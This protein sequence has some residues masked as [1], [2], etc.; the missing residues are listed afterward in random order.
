[1]DGVL[2]DTRKMFS[3]TSFIGY[4]LGLLGLSIFAVSQFI[5][6]IIP[7]LFAPMVCVT[8]GLLLNK[9]Q[10]SNQKKSQAMNLISKPNTNSSQR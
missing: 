8:L 4:I 5:T 3:V 6:A 10:P 2:S 1:M 7:L 9:Y